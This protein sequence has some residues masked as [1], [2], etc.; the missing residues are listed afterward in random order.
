MSLTF[1]TFQK[2][3][4]EFMLEGYSPR[5]A[6]H[7]LDYLHEPLTAL[8]EIVRM[9][10]GSDAALVGDTY[11]SS[12]MH[13]N[14]LR[15]FRPS[16]ISRMGGS[17]A[18][19][20]AAW[21]MGIMA[22]SPEVWSI[23]WE[24]A[25][26]LV[27]YHRD[28]LEKAGVE[29]ATA[30]ATSAQCEATLQKLQQAG[31]AHPIGMPTSGMD[32]L[33]Q[34]AAWLREQGDIMAPDQKHVAFDT[35]GAKAG[36]VAFFR[37]FRYSMPGTRSEWMGNF[38]HK[39]IPV[40]LNGSWLW[41]TCQKYMPPAELARVRLTSPPGVPFLGGEHLVIWEHT[42]RV[43]ETLRLVAHLASPQT[44]ERC[45]SNRDLFLTLPARRD[46]FDG[47]VFAAHLQRQNLRAIM[48]KASGFHAWRLS[49]TIQERL[50]QCL[51]TIARAVL[52]DPAADIPGLVD[53]HIDQ[54]AFRLNLALSA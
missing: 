12:L 53:E 26:R 50:Q 16:E 23:P 33:F 11:V 41:D 2:T 38:I 29:E 31:F 3:Q 37:L 48:E 36:L 8:R 24:V 46:V 47:P 6:V 34:S 15:P 25:P 22:D 20:P 43:E 21:K 1:T 40:C 44:A 27:A 5:P 54:A 19:L 30:F 28:M 18:F 35:P 51:E 32:L 9:R 10:R 13:M 52:A 45:F 39:K 7:A 4:T 14:A 49:G 42:M 17:E